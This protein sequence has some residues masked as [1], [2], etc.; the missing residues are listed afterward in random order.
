MADNYNRVNDMKST[1]KSRHRHDPISHGTGSHTRIFNK[2]ESIVCIFFVTIMILLIIVYVCVLMADGGGSKAGRCPVNMRSVFLWV[3]GEAFGVVSGFLVVGITENNQRCYAQWIGKIF[4]SW[5]IAVL[6]IGA[7][8]LIE[9]MV[10]QVKCGA[11]T[12][13]GTLILYWI[14]SILSFIPI[15]IILIVTVYKYPIGEGITS[16]K[17]SIKKRK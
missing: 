11:F 12:T 8:V 16:S 3:S 2:L 9:M 6:F 7:G 15:L 10:F 14:L 17:P 1:N 4:G 13:I 5:M